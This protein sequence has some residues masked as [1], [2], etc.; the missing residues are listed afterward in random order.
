VNFG[1]GDKVWRLN[2]AKPILYL[3]T[4]ILGWLAKGN[5]AGAGTDIL[6]YLASTYQLRMVEQV[7][8]EF[9]PDD[10][11]FN[12]GDSAFNR[13]LNRAELICAPWLVSPAASSPDCRV[14]S[15]STAMAARA[16]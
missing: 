2:V 15:L 6:T 9:L 8:T 3:D 10:T 5:G 13:R 11:T 7:E 4:M 1:F 12:Y 14:M 16:D